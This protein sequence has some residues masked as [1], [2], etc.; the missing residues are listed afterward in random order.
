[1]DEAA[2]KRGRKPDPVYEKLVELFLDGGDDATEIAAAAMGR[3]P[4]TVRQGLAGAIR[5]MGVGDQLLVS[6]VSG[7][8]A[9]AGASALLDAGT[10]RRRSPWTPP[11]PRP[12]TGSWHPMTRPRRSLVANSR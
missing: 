1:M 3:T 9:S 5:R 6:V 8:S 4:S 12:S 7:E 2:P 10:R 11:T